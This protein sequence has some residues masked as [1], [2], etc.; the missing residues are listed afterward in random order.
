MYGNKIKINYRVNNVMYERFHLFLILIFSDAV[1][2]KLLSLGKKRRRKERSSLN[3]YE[4]KVLSLKMD[5]YIIAPFLSL[6]RK[7]APIKIS[8]D[9]EYIINC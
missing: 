1:S 5:G 3:N 2:W 9:F 7:V 4:I 6:V 8:T